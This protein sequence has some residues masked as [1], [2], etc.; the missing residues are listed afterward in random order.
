MQS[1]VLAWILTSLAGTL[2]HFIYDWWPNAL[3]ALIAPINESIWEHL[4]LFF[5]P[6]LIVVWGSL[7]HKMEAWQAWAGHLAA[8]LAMPGLLLGSYYALAA[9]FDCRAGWLNI[10]LYYL[11]LALGFTLARH[12]GRSRSAIRA[13]PLLLLAVCFYA[14]LLTLF[15]FAAPN[16]PVFQSPTS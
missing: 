13:A 8:L 11:I 1:W 2:L 15:S 9:G 12:I 5:W 10:A 6:Y 14:L 3:T 4:K 7:R 16:L